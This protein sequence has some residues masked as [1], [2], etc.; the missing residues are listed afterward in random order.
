MAMQIS[1]TVLNPGSTNLPD[2]QAPYVGL[3]R[4]SEQLVSGVHGKYYANN[5]RGNMYYA[6]N[7]AAGAAFSIFSATTFIGLFLI[8]PQGSGKNLSIARVTLGMN[9][10][11]GTAS[12]GW[13]YAWLNNAG[14]GLINTQITAIAP[15][16]ATRGSCICGPAGQ[17]SSVAIAATTATLA[18]AL[19][20]GRCASFTTANG[21]VTVQMAST[22]VEDLDG[23]MI[24]P[25]GT[26]WALT[27][28]ILTG[29]TGT[30]TIT[31]EELPL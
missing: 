18:A 7:A 8:N 10:A 9:T 4:Q 12:S 17:G 2:G 1:G 15:I 27:S 21:A 5:Y 14:T 24:V 31:W 13:G 28:A 20:W 19:V 11:A 29:L 16:T 25:P 6:T 26:M 23:T 3:G 30:G 22:L